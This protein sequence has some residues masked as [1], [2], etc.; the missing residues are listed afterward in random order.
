M[1]NLKINGEEISRW[2]LKEMWEAEDGCIDWKYIDVAIRKAELKGRQDALKEVEKIYED[3][4]MYADMNEDDFWKSSTIS[5]EEAQKRADYCRELLEK[6]K[7]GD[8]K[9]E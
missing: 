9:D 2:N 8:K 4:Q 7:Q 3:Y 6:L 1:I 5:P